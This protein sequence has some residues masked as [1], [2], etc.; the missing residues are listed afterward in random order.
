[1]PLRIAVI[2]TETTWDDA[3]MT[4]GIIVADADTLK[5]V[6]YKYFVIPDATRRGGMYSASIN[7]DGLKI[8]RLPEWGAILGTV[9]FLRAHNVTSLFAYNAKFDKRHLNL[10][11][12]FKWY[13]I[14]KV[15]AYKQY[16]PKIPVE[17][18]CCKT[19]RLKTGFGVQN[20]MQ[21]LTEA[22]YQETHNAVV[23]ALD[24]LKIMRLLNLPLD[25]YPT[26]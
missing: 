4:I 26:V 23:D 25:I 7:I 15:A 17:A 22:P 6:A 11:D 2:D 12:R 8:S 14:L 13:D 3:L 18:K 9:A 1:M 24:E 5:P 21:L 20:I 19:G 10:S 16:N